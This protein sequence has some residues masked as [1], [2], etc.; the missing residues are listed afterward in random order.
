MTDSDG[1]IYPPPKEG[2][3]FLVVTFAD[4]AVKTQAAATRAEARVLLASRI[5]RVRPVA[6]AGADVLAA[7]PQ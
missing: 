5:R 7:A 3:P 4:G 2:L 1:A 6:V